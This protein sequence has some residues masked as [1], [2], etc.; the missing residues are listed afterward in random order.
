MI[1]VLR[2]VARLAIL[3]A[4]A[5]FC[6]PALAQDAFPSRPDFAFHCATPL[7]VGLAKMV[8]A[9]G[10]LRDRQPAEVRAADR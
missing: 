4:V 1:R 2:A 5:S 3:G 9:S 8:E 10:P 6:L 7:G